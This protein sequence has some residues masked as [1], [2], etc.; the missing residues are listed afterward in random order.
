MSSF[1]VAAWPIIAKAVPRAARLGVAR[2]FWQH[3]V[4]G[5]LDVP[6]RIEE[7]SWFDRADDLTVEE[8][9]IWGSGSRDGLSC[10]RR[11]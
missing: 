11:I 9:E 4:Y 1:R 3:D 5:F 10:F 7:V 2:R 6:R 8:A